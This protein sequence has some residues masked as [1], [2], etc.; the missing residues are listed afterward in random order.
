MVQHDFGSVED[1]ES[2]LRTCRT[3]GA[4]KWRLLCWLA[5]LSSATTGAYT[6]RLKTYT[7]W[8]TDTG[9]PWRHTLTLLAFLWKRGRA[10]MAVFEATF[11]NCKP[12]VHHE[13][14]QRFETPCIE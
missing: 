8:A 5:A 12:C 6:P 10:G 11:G 13:S 4:A 2:W 3:K 1:N 9:R 14:E 7:A